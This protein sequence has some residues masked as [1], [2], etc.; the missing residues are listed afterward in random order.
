MTRLSCFCA[1]LV[2]FV[3]CQS[4]QSEK[5]AD[6]TPAIDSSAQASVPV[7][8][9]NA[10]A[11]LY[12]GITPCQDCEGVE[13]SLTLST[14]TTY[15][16]KLVYLGKDNAA[17]VEATGRFRWN[18]GENSITLDGLLNMP[19]R[20]T[21]GTNMLMQMDLTGQPIQGALAGKYILIKQ[22][23]QVVTIMKQ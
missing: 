20:Y 19:S 4:N 21:V 18:P 9:S 6:T 13:T 1:L 11:G 14:D 8:D 15:A 12:K 17:P 10:W 5:P 2:I 16:L 3:A 23:P 22:A 7:I